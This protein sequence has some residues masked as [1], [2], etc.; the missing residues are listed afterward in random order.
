MMLGIGTDIVAV[1]RVRRL[2]ERFPGR[3]PRRILHTDE[4]DE[5]RE[6]LDKDAFLAR[7]FAAKE[8]VGK[9]LGSGFS[10]L[11]ARR[12][13]IRH[14]RRGRPEVVLSMQVAPKVAPRVL[15]SISDEKEYATAMATATT[16][17][18][19]EQNP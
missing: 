7:R 17:G 18:A 1:A 10:G 6:S 19:S 3:F 2:R 9:A 16:T 12:I 8:A 15:V 13:R 5:Y 14:D 11:P 4:L